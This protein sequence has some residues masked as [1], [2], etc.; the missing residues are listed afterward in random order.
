MEGNNPYGVLC[1]CVMRGIHKRTIHHHSELIIYK[2]PAL[3]RVFC[4]YMFRIAINMLIWRHVLLQRP[5]A[6]QKLISGTYTKLANL[7]DAR[8]AATGQLINGKIYV[9]GGQRYSTYRNSCYAYDIASNQWIARANAPEALSMLAS[10]TID[11]QLYTFG[12][13]LTT[14]TTSY[15]RAYNP[16]TN[17]WTKKAN[18]L[19][20]PRHS[21][22]AT[23]IG[24]KGYIF[25]GFS[26]QANNDLW[27]YDS[28]TDTTRRLAVGGLDARNDARA[29]AL[30][31]KVYITGGSGG[32]A[33][34]LWEY[35]PS[36]DAWTR[37]ADLPVG[38]RRD[39]PGFVAVGDKLYLFGG[40]DPAASGYYMNDLWCFD[41]A[42]NSW[43]EII[44]DGELPAG[45]REMVA[46]AD[47]Q[48]IFVATGYNTTVGGAGLADMWKIS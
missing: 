36:N 22:C 15:I 31:G 12:G 5:Q 34:D 32:G 26:G 23:A 45:R 6:I 17:T 4:K 11:G 16:S 21:L 42:T 25:G 14:G 30:N 33:A 8:Y 20:T 7:F 29:A 37:L 27:E 13:S 43:S 38:G 47:D 3:R 48:S 39:A 9:T 41:P 28:V 18:G 10:A 40:S 35:S 19:F 46:V 44:S 1:D 24:S 2:K